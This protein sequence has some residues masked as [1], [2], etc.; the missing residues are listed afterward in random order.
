MI[1]FYTFWCLVNTGL[2]LLSV[3]YSLYEIKTLKQ[4]HKEELKQILRGISWAKRLTENHLSVNYTPLDMGLI[5]NNLE[6]LIHNIKARND[7]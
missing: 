5:D 4:K 3:F 7:L 6:M 1:T 2:F